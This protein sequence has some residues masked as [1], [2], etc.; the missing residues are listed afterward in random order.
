MGMRKSKLMICS[1]RYASVQILQGLE[2]AFI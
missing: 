2:P 1:Y